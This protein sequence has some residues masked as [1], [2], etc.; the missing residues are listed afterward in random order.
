MSKSRTAI[1]TI[2]LGIV[3][4]SCAN[5]DGNNTVSQN[6]ETTMTIMDVEGS[7]SSVFGQ[8][9]DIKLII[10]MCNLTNETQPLR[11]SSGQHYD[12]EIYDSDD[13][14]IWNW[15]NDKAFI[16]AETELVFN[17]NEVKIFEEKWD[18]I[19]NDGNLISPDTYN[20]EFIGLGSLRFAGPFSFEIW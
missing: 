10:N 20:A 16:Q 3:F 11:F 9:E 5:D 17:P 6:I 19:S 14:L 8:G 15:A 7:E 13:N 4:L 2:F 12:I 18:Q 1:L